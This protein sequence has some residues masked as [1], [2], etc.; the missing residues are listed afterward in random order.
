MAHFVVKDIPQVYQRALKLHADGKLEE[1]HRL[2]NEIIALRPN[3]AEVHY[4]V[5][6]IAHQVRDYPTAVAAFTNARRL[7]PR[8]AAILRERATTNTDAG[9]L[10]EAIA[11]WVEL[12]ELSGKSADF[13]FQIGLLYQRKGE[14]DSA[15]KFMRKAL[16]LSPG[17]G[18]IYRGWLQARKLKKGDPLI[19]EMLK[20]HADKSVTGLS[21][22]QL[23]FALAKAMEEIGQTDK[24]FRFL[25][26]GNRLYANHAPV[27]RKKKERETERR[28]A[29][30]E[31]LDYSGPAPVLD[32][33]SFGPIFVAGLPRSGTTLVEQI[34]VS[35]SL[36]SGAGETSIVPRMV[37]HLLRA[38]PHGPWKPAG[39]ITESEAAAFRDLLRKE[40]FRVSRFSGH[41]VTDKTITNYM[42]IGLIKKLV[43]N[44]RVILVRRDP[45][46]QLLSMYRNVFGENSHLHAYDLEDLA[47]H[48]HEFTRYVEF[49][50]ERCSHLFTEVVY[51]D[52]VNDPEVQSRKLIAAAGLEW[53]DACLNFHETKRDVK[54]LSIHQVRQPMYKSSAKAWEKYADDLKP[55]T[56][57]LERYGVLDWHY[58]T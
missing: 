24:V 26:E 45:R 51:E 58:K 15:D 2:Y 25:N 7:K 13:Y 29:S 3:I 5:G 8:E 30:L 47:H 27:D 43:P 42:Y 46:D 44:A 33:E 55:L 36:V 53:E 32:N 11:D 37:H 12:V 28:L 4:Q 40:L 22:A 6:R 1:A 18:Q 14:F 54:T 57:A 56:E 49:W 38:G 35:H 20:A 16:R 34:L 41:L 52:L 50:R 9:N 39:E 17:N 21:R 10:D 48:Y 23:C 31:T 19:A